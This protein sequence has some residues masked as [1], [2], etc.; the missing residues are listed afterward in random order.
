MNN[1][2]SS[3][4]TQGTKQE[5]AKSLWT[6]CALTGEALKEP[7]V[8]CELGKLYNRD[9]VIEFLMKD[10]VFVYSQE[11]LKK[12][13][14]GHIVSLKSVFEVKLTRNETANLKK[15]VN[16]DETTSYVPG[17][18]VCPVTQLE[19]NGI[20]PFCALRAC[21]HVISEK[22]LNLFAAMSACPVCSTPYTSDGIYPI[23]GNESAVADLEKRMQLKRKNGSSEKKRKEKKQKKEKKEK[24]RKVA[25]DKDNTEN[26][27]EYPTTTTTP[28]PS[29]DNSSPEKCSYTSDTASES[30]IPN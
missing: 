14:F 23:Y 19:T 3:E 17:L 28:T 21:G 16:V 20:H 1:L 8:T 10:G 18:F 29:E 9:S 15:P 2:P 7:I 12:N 22:A 6:S 25:K 11:D 5:Q 26:V 13:G 4:P 27:P 30:R 24:R